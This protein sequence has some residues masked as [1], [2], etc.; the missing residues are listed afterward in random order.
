MS[1]SL[2]IP[3]LHTQRDIGKTESLITLFQSIIYSETNN[4][5]ELPF[6]DHPNAKWLLI[7][8]GHLEENLTTGDLF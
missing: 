4:I 6:S 3:L 8:L 1:I 5:F 7:G 2:L